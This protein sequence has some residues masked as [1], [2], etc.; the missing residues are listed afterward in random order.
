MEDVSKI[1]PL[2]YNPKIVVKL[3]SIK[4]GQY[5][6]MSKAAFMELLDF[7]EKNDTVLV[8]DEWG[9]EDRKRSDENGNK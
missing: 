8:I 6:K 7:Y 2:R 1:K 3:Q 4:T 9:I 5:K